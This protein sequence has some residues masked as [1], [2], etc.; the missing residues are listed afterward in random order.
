MRLVEYRE[1][2]EPLQGRSHAGYPIGVSPVCTECGERLAV[3][4]RP[5][6]P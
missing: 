3:P 5:A 4:E 1:C 6:T 2:L